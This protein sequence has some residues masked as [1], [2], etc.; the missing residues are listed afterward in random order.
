[1]LGSNADALTHETE[2]EREGAPGLGKARADKE[3]APLSAHTQKTEGEGLP[4]PSHGGQMHPFFGCTRQIVQVEA[5]G[6]AEQLQCPFRLTDASQ[7][8]RVDGWGERA[9]MSR[10]GIIESHARLQ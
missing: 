2:R 1:M 10:P 8:R 7:Q 9:G 6:Q 4:C 3:C 5:G